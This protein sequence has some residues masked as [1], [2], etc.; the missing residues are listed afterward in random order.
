MQVVTVEQGDRSNVA[1]EASMPPPLTASRFDLID[2]RIGRIACYGE[3]LTGAT[4]PPPPSS[5]PPADDAS[6]SIAAPG[7]ETTSES[8]T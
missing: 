7:A 3:A 8:K 4:L 2:P 5:P 6:T 1:R